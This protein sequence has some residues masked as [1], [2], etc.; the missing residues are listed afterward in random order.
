AGEEHVLESTFN[1]FHSSTT[2]SVTQALEHVTHPHHG[3]LQHQLDVV[4]VDA[5]LAGR[6]SGGVIDHHADRRIGQLQF[7][8]ERGLR[9]S[10]HADDVAAVALEAVDL[11][12]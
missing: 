12:C 4:E 6:A 1:T 3:F 7:A 8:G 10:G 11:R 5:V 9:H 2:S